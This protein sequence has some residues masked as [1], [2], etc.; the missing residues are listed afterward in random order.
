MNCAFEIIHFHAGITEPN[1]TIKISEMIEKASNEKKAEI[2]VLLDEINTCNCLDYISEIICE[3]SYKGQALPENLRFVATCN[4]Y[5]QRKRQKDSSAAGLV[6]EN[7]DTHK[8]QKLVY[9]VNPLPHSIMNFVLNFGS[10][11]PTD[12][13]QYIR[14]MLA[15]SESFVQE[16]INFAV[17]I[18]QTS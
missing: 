6:K 2:W 12:E 10:L 14:K 8:Q 7:H 15:G 5:K 1:L 3:R 9:T 16:N 13:K 4:P 11:E 18:I 17:E